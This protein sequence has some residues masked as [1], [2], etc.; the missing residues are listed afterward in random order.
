MRDNED[1]ECATRECVR[2]PSFSVSVT[3]KY[4][5]PIIRG[6]ALVRPVRHFFERDVHNAKFSFPRVLCLYVVD[7]GVIIDNF[8]CCLCRTSWDRFLVQGTS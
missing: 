1:S 5:W 2:F 8:D 7:V 4:S 3:M 6:G